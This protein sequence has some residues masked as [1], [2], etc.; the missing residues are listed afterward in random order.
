VVVVVDAGGFGPTVTVVVAVN[1]SGKKI[2]E[3]V[4]IA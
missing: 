4:G 2:Q 1:S 3:V